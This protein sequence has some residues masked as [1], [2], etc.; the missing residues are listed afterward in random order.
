MD[1][2]SV[3]SILRLN[4]SLSVLNEDHQFNLHVG[5][6]GFNLRM[7]LTDNRWTHIPLWALFLYSDGPIFPFQ[8]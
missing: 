4:P 8:P 5:K 1:M 2:L 6:N 7:N 3:E